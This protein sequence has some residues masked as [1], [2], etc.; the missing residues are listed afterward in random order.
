MLPLHRRAA[1]AAAR[2]PRPRARCRSRADRVRSD[3]ARRRRAGRSAAIRRVVASRQA[4]AGLDRVAPS[5]RTSMVFHAGVNGTASGL[6]TGGGR[7]LTVVGRGATFHARDRSR[8]RGGVAHHVRRH[9]V[10]ARHRRGRPS[11]RMKYAIVTFGCRVNQADSLALEAELAARRRGSRLRRTRRPRDRQHVL[12]DGQRRSGRASD[13]PPHRRAKSGGADRRDRMLCHALRRRR[14]RAAE[15]GRASC[16][17]TTRHAA[18]AASPRRSRF[19]RRRGRPSRI[20]RSSPGWPAA[21]RGRCACR[22]AARS[23]AA[24]ASSR[25]R[26]AAAGAGRST[27]SSRSRARSSTPV[28]RRSHHRRAPRLVRTRPA[29]ALVTG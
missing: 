26:A 2:W 5:A 21:P 6:V 16:R 20:A 10:P 24:T 27:T 3:A 4:I 11:L 18:R 15:R 28:T 12:G 22:P 29:Q 7:V 23:R 25:R 9:A 13:D 19:R 1:G 8:L 17:T 14:R